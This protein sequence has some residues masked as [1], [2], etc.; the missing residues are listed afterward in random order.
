MKDMGQYEGKTFDEVVRPCLT[1]SRKRQSRLM[2]VRRR[3]AH[4]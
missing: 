1:H 2:V 4:R 3:S